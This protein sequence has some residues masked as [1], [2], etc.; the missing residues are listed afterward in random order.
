MENV[1]LFPIICLSKILLIIAEEF[2]NVARLPDIF[3]STTT[4][5]EG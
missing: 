2:H 4:K 1:F 5:P 3:S